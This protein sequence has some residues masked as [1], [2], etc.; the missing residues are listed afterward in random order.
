MRAQKPTSGLV[1]FFTFDNTLANTANTDTILNRT[2]N[3]ELDKCGN[4]NGAHNVSNLS[5]STRY[6]QIDYLSYGNAAKSISLWFKSDNT[7]SISNIFNYG[8]AISG[9]NYF[10]YDAATNE[11]GYGSSFG[12]LRAVVLNP[13]KWTHIVATLTTNGISNLYINSVSV[14]SSQNRTFSTVPQ[15]FT[16][17]GRSRFGGVY[18][19]AYYIDNLMLY[20]IEL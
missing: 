17:L 19:G 18:Y 12:E 9:Y 13:E 5:S 14:A 15:N 7:T 16:R 4:A 8:N 6:A 20:N 2:Y 1:N 3:G 11:I 10:F